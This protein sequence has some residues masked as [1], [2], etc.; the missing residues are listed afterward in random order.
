MIIHGAWPS[1]SFKNAGLV[2]ARTA[3]FFLRAYAEEGEPVED[4][5]EC[6]DGAHEPAK[7]PSLKE[8]AHDESDGEECE[9]ECEGDAW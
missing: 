6:S 2:C 7:T 9:K 4:A 5:E 3:F 8:D 1:W